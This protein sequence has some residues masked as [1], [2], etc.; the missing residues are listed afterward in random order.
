MSIVRAT[1]VGWLAVG[2]GAALLGAGPAAGAT[3][4]RIG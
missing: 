1:V 3:D 4:L 2:L